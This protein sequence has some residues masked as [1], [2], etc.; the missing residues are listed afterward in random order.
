MNFSLKTSVFAM[1]MVIKLTFS[2]ELIDRIVAV[3]GEDIILKSEVDQFVEQKK[4]FG[5]AADDQ[6]LRSEALDE[7]ISVK[8]LYDIAKRDTT[9]AVS[10]E[11][12][13]TVLDSR[14]NPI[15]QQVGGE[16]RFEEIYNTTV[17]DLRRHYRSEIRKGLLVDRLK[18][19]HLS[20]IS[21]SRREV[22]KFY[23]TYK[24]SIPPVKPSVTLSQLV[25][26]ISGDAASDAGALRRITDIRT[27]IISGQI[28]F[29]QAAEK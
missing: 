27:D 17:S 14:I 2:M 29:E 7:L 11:E 1:L 8:I 16:K 5:T 13:Q 12:V 22:E 3:V 9:I 28:S 25:I 6:V 18:N 24:D 10:D 21:A 23:K 15:I 19:K 4:I 26:S 20:G